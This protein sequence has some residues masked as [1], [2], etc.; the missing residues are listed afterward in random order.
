M[1]YRKEEQTEEENVVIA[2]EGH[3]YSRG[4]V[5]RERLDVLE[6]T[7]IPHADLAIAHAAK[8]SR[9]DT[10]VLAHP[11]DTG[12][13]DAAMALSN[14]HGLSAGA[15]VEQ[16]DLAVAR[17]GSEE[18]ASRAECHALDSIPVAGEDGAWG[19]GGAKVPE[20]DGIVA[21]CAREDV[22]CGG[23]PEDLADLAWGRVDA[24]HG[25]K[26]LRLPAVRGPVLEHGR[27][28]LPDHHVAVL[29]PRRDDRI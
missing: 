16:S 28:H 19:F 29:A 9:P 13:L 7:S 5:E 15:R 26:V 23:V 10:I 17:C 27:L 2:P 24:Q 1:L 3:H 8:P 20:F 14:T 4:L 22:L 18:L 11:H 25:R 6:R 21:N 12:A